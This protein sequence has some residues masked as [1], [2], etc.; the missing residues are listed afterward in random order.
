MEEEGVV[1]VGEEA[2]QAEEAALVREGRRRK[3]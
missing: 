1:V 3:W 2:T